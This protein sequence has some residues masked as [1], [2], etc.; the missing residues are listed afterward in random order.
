MSAR[1]AGGARGLRDAHLHL[2]QYGRSLAMI[3]LSACRGGAEML[4]LVANAAL[5]DRGGLVLADKAR[6]EAWDPPG[7]VSL[8]ELD[9]VTGDALF[10]AWCFDYHAIMANSAALRHAGINSGSP[11]PEGGVIGRD[12]A[13]RPTGVLYERAAGMLW[14]S[15]PDP[16]LPRA[17]EILRRAVDALRAHGFVEV[18]DLKAQ[19]WLGDEL[20]RLADAGGLEGFN[21]EIW[22]LV[23]DL[24]A[25]VATRRAW[26]RESVGLG[27]GKIFVDGTLNSRTAWMLR[28][29]ADADRAGRPGLP[30]GLAMMT[31][32]QIEDAVRRCDGLGVPLAAHAIGDAAVRAV[33]DAIEKVR[34]RTPGFRIEHAELVDEADVPRFA[35]LGV[36]C[37]VQ[38][39]HLLYDIEALRRGVPDRLDRVLPLR[40]LIDAGCEPGRVSGGGLVFGSDAPIVR[41]DPGDSVQG[42]VARRR[43]GMGEDEAVGLG[44]AVT[45]VE[46]WACF[47]VERSP[48]RARRGLRRSSRSPRP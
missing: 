16:D 45:E 27:G 12:G 18:H 23:E 42:A 5:R 15:L 24:E 33:L 3:D 28:P 32:G 44:E 31:P 1:G 29:Y 7:W 35:A 2:Y 47:G 25:V 22:P 13:G 10:A 40:S 20:A 6:P 46:A 14:E 39:C 34:P 43:V 19:P 9:R 36:T 38:P 41:P 26:E 30:C 4:N 21:V 11:D 17:G 37:S 8:A 48:E